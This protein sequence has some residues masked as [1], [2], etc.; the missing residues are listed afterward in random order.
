MARDVAPALLNVLHLFDGL[1]HPP[2][3]PPL[4]KWLATSPDLAHSDVAARCLLA[5]EDQ[6]P[7]RQL[8][9]VLRPPHL[10]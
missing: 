7:G 2:F 8:H 3:H 6:L 9:H 5:K 1:V 4:G 10:G